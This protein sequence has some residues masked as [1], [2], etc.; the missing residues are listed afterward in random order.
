[1]AKQYLLHTIENIE[2]L[3]PKETLQIKRKP[4]GINNPLFK[5]FS[6]DTNNNNTL[7]HRVL[8]KEID[9][10]TPLY[11]RYRRCL[12]FRH[13]TACSIALW[14]RWLLPVGTTLCWGTTPTIWC[15]RSRQSVL[16]E[17]RFVL[18]RSL[19]KTKGNNIKIK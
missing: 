3:V 2:A 14:W 12:G 6:D 13:P 1:M 10:S 19:E 11:Q 7:F 17:R 9:P 15:W 4:L 5:K 8:C 18:L 16:K